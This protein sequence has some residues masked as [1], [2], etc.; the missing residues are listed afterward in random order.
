[1]S[2]NRFA[3]LGA[4]GSGKSVFAK[5]LLAAYVKVNPVFRYY[6]ISTKDSP[7]YPDPVNKSGLRDLGFEAIHINRAFF[8]AR[9][10]E[11]SQ[12]DWQA[13]IRA[14]PRACFILSSLENEEIIE[15][16]NLLC[17]AIHDVGR[18][19]VWLDEGMLFFPANRSNPGIEILINAGREQQ[20]D[21][22]VLLQHGAQSTKAIERSVSSTGCMVAFRMV[23]KN[24]Y[25]RYKTYFA[26]PDEG[27]KAYGD[28]LANLPPYHFLFRTPDGEV[29]Q[30]CNE[31]FQLVL[32]KLRRHEVKTT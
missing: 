1:M 5:M 32:N 6:C 16:A 7:L 22:I 28:R 30:W 3:V 12:V 25:D 8:D 11:I 21:V 4:T 31:N 29:G 18:A 27:G 19:A 9:H 14:Y 17:R 13:V 23:E 10:I 26:Q 20:V 24:E 2:A 15:V